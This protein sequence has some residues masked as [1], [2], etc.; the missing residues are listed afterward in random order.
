MVKTSQNNIES[1]AGIYDKKCEY[2]YTSA[3]L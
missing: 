1:D 3:R 2:N